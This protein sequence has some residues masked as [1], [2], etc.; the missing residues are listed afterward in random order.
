MPHGRQRH[1][2]RLI[3]IAINAAVP[4]I[5]PRLG[6]AALAPYRRTSILPREGEYDVF[7]EAELLRVTLFD[8]RKFPNPL[9]CDG[10]PDEPL[11]K[12]RA[13]EGAYDTMP[14]VMKRFLSEKLWRSQPKAD[15][16]ELIRNAILTLE[17]DKDRAILAPYASAV[18]KE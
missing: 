3:V 2:L 10:N 9:L 17:P 5:T 4:G 14:S 18:Q 16:S 13:A 1:P 11:A 7:L 12:I 6:E 15:S 8:S